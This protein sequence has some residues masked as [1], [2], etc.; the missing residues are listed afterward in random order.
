[1]SFTIR[2]GAARVGILGLMTLLFALTGAAVQPGQSDRDEAA[3]GCHERDLLLTWI[4][5]WP[6]EHKLV[7]EHN[8]VVLFTYPHPARF[9]AETASIYELDSLSCVDLN[10]D[11]EVARRVNSDEGGRR[12][13]D[14][15]VTDEPLMQ[16]IRSLIPWDSRSTPLPSLR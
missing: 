14:R 16:R 5:E 2:S 6:H 4:A 7:I 13:L 12:R 8:L 1:M 3:T 15:V 10:A 9:W 11:G